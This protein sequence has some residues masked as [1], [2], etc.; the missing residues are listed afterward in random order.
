MIGVVV[1]S[2]SAAL[3]RGVAEL[4]AEMAPDVTIAV[5]GGT[6]DGEIGTS[7]DLV[8]A[9]LSEADSGDGVVVLTDLGSATMTAE[10]ALELLDDDQRARVALVDAPLVEGA[11]AAATT[12]GAG[13]GLDEVRAAA[14]QAGATWSTAPTPAPPEPAA[15]EPA[16]PEPVA[17]DPPAPD[18]PAA[19]QGGSAA[20]G[21]QVREVVLRNPLGLHARPAALL[22]RR[23]KGLD[24]VLRVTRTDTGQ[25]VDGRSVLGLVSLGAPGATPLR[26]T[27]TGTEAAAALDAYAAM[28]E[29]GFGE[30]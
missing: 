28:I 12:A 30:A 6:G 10:M 1:V 25:D 20:A 26:L 15:P 14:E 3:A 13:A 24:A 22:A 8:S 11:I 5:A 16:P 17:P 23:L 29:E 7:L 9:A 27:A 2:H 21:E 19:E 18:P 4:A